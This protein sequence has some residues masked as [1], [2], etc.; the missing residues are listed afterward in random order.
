MTRRVARR[1]SGSVLYLR[2]VPQTLVREA[3]AAAARRGITLTALV[4]ETLAGALQGGPPGGTSHLKRPLPADFRES[5]AWFEAHRETLKRRYAGEYLAIV[6]N[7]VVD[8][9]REFDP[10]ARRVFA[11]LGVR[12]IFMP[13]IPARRGEDDA[14]VINIPSPRLLRA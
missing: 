7:R 10:L 3:K 11:R 9:D 6:K 8:H 2:G 4:T 1:R 13:R 12:P 14:E 5:M